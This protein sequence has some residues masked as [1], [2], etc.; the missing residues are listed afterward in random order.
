MKMRRRSTTAVLVFLWLTFLPAPALAVP[1]HGAMIEAFLKQATDGQL[2]FVDLI[3]PFQKVGPFDFSLKPE[4]AL[5]YLG[6]PDII[7]FKDRTYTLKN[8]PDRYY[9][10]YNSVGVSFLFGGGA[11]LEVTAISPRF[12]F[13]N[14]IGVGSAEAQVIA[15]FGKGF[16]LIEDASQD[17]LVYAEIGVSFRVSRQKRIVWEIALVPGPGQAAP[18]PTFAE[19]LN[20]EVPKLDLSQTTLADLVR[21][22][23]E[24]LAYRW[25]NKT[26]S[27]D[28]LPP[29]C[30]AEFKDGFTALLQGTAVVE[31]GFHQSGFKFAAQLGVGSTL[32]EA[33]AVLG[34]PSDT[35]QGQSRNF[36]SGVL[37]VNMAGE[38]GACYYERAEWGV[39]LFFKD[40]KVSALYLT[41]PQ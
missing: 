30:I 8:L 19:L 4:D 14:G 34:E 22:F 10:V 11:L 17:A 21:A 40:F 16:K 18:A 33:L 41:A 12:K 13:P 38:K 37:Y 26:Y 7:F 20:R 24:P 29:F 2:R 6:E 9:F 35:V 27:R 25:G 36:K 5:L 39:R 1:D 32:A 23:G 28:A 15:A 31:L 3:I